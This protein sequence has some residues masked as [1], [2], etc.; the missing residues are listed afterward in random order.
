MRRKLRYKPIHLNSRIFDPSPIRCC[1]VIGMTLLIHLIRWA[2]FWNRD[3]NIDANTS[4]IFWSNLPWNWRP[5][6]YP[7]CGRLQYFMFASK[8]KSGCTTTDD[9]ITDRRLPTPRPSLPCSLYYPQLRLHGFAGTQVIDHTGESV[10]HF[11]TEG[12]SHFHSY[13][14]NSIFRNQELALCDWMPKNNDM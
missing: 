7:V 2:S 9:R 12:A 8:K 11:I 10:L 5:F 13:L 1:Q 14:A 3:P 6:G 4:Y